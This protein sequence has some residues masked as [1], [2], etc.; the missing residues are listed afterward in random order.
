MAHAIATRDEDHRGRRESRHEQ[1]VV[2]GA[3]DH[4]LVAQGATLTG[5][6][7]EIDDLDGAAG[8]RIG[9]DFIDADGHATACGNSIAP[10]SD[11]CEYRVA[12]S[13]IDITD[14]DFNARPA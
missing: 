10:G 14:I 5:G 1:R 6:G 4:S 11:P 13:L 3:A 7:D 12:P 9:I 8:R 2:V